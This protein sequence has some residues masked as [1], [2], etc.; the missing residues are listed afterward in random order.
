MNEKRAALEAAIAD[1]N[2]AEGRELIAPARHLLPPMPSVIPTGLD[3]LDRA[4]GIGGIPAGRVTEI[5]GEADGGKTSLALQVAKQ[6]SPDRPALYIDGEHHLAPSTL[7]MIGVPDDSVY[8]FRAE[9]LQDALQVC[10]AAAPA[11][12]AVII[13]SI[14]SLP[15]KAELRPKHADHVVIQTH[16]ADV[17]S[18]GLAALAPLLKRTGCALILVNQ[19]RDTP[20]CV[21]GMPGHSPGGRALKYYAALRLELFRAGILRD[22][23]KD[24]GRDTGIR[25]KVTVEKNK[26]AAPQKSALIDLDFVN[27]LS[28]RPDDRYI[29]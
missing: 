17:L 20:G 25:I 7:R 24:R 27:G 1:I 5:F 4:L 18:H 6:C 8:L 15:V 13:D 11:F 19:L 12:G 16:Q 23:P 14:S 10:K 2:R 3:G 9:T 26:C 22:D 21:W 28:E 29:F